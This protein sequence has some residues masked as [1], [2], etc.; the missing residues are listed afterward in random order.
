MAYQM[1]PLEKHWRNEFKRLK[2][3]TLESFRQRTDA[4]HRAWAMIYLAYARQAW[5]TLA[6]NLGR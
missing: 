4:V 2:R 6:R 5:K 1:G 3:L